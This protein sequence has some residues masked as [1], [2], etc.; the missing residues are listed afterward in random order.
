TVSRALS[1]PSM[2]RAE[3]RARIHN[4][5]S[6]LGYVPDAAARALVFRRTRIVGA[7]VPTLDHAIFSRAI[8]AMQI[9]LAEA[10]YQLLI[11]SHE[12]SPVVETSAVRSLIEQGVDGLMLVGTDHS[13]EVWTMI[14]NAAIPTVLTWS[15]HEKFDSVGFDNEAAGYFAARHL[16]QL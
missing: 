11:A 3:T 1:N 10:D 6:E 15:L 8:H 2:V 12:Y 16:L 7:V 13:R 9:T 14:A 5:I 4:V